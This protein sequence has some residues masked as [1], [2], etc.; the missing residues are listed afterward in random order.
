MEGM[1]NGIAA[2]FIVGILGCVAVAI[3]GIAKNQ[4]VIAS[5]GGVGGFSLSVGVR[6]ITGGKA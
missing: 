6:A 2:V 1:K 5:M 3:F 4:P